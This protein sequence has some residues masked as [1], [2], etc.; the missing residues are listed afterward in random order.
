VVRSYLTARWLAKL[1][2]ENLSTGTLFDLLFA[3]SYGLEVVK[4]QLT[5]QPHG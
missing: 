2:N 3:K 4:L 1:R 5:K